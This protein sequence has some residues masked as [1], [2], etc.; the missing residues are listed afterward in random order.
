MGIAYRD[1]VSGQTTCAG[2]VLAMEDGG[3]RIQNLRLLQAYAREYEDS[4]YH[5]ISGFVRFLDK[6]R[7]NDSDLQA[8]RPRRSSETPCR[9]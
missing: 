8:R 6:L 3:D 2:T 5:G 9:S 4:G 1:E 7:R